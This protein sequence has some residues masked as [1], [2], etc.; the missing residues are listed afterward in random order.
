[1]RQQLGQ[2]IASQVWVVL[3]SHL[4]HEAVLCV[5]RVQPLNEAERELWMQEVQLG[6]RLK[7]PHLAQVLEIGVHEGWPFVI[8]AR[9]DWLTLG[10]RLAEGA[11]LTA[12]EAAGI[13]VDVLDGLAYAHEAGLVH[14]DIGLHSVLLDHSGRASLAALGVGL[15]GL[16]TSAIDVSDGLL[17]DLGH[18]LRRSRV[19]VSLCLDE[20][21]VSPWLAT[22]SPDERLD[23]ILAGGD[24]YELLFTTPPAQRERVAQLGA[25]LGLVL[26]RIG[27]IEAEPGLRL[28]RGASAVA[29]PGEGREAV[30]NRWTSFDHFKGVA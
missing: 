5:P 12:Q 21:P 8:L 25:E 11:P 1:L 7:H 17:G 14:H 22:R 2:S 27:Q 19:G 4:Q 15:R 28:W 9:G 13:V 3:D 18:V 30:P 10:E 29:E 24:D 6:A 23:C 16:A 20:L 26:S